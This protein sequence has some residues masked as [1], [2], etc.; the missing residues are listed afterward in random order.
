MS[1]KV[2]R[3]HNYGPILAALVCVSIARPDISL[4]CET[5]EYCAVC[6]FTSHV[7][8]AGIQCAYPRRNGQAELTWVFGYV[9]SPPADGYPFHYN[10]IRRRVTLLI[11]SRVTYF[12]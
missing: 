12:R 7:A 9:V 2:F 10:G 3:A 11:D 1:Y 6:S 5:I 8:F 4:H